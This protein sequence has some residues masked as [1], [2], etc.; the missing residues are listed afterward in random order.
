VPHHDRTHSARLTRVVDIVAGSAIVLKGLS[1]M[2]QPEPFWLLIAA[3]LAGGT[4]ILLGAIFHHRLKQRFHHFAAV[5]SLVE[6]VTS[7]LVGVASVKHG[8]HLI[9]YTWFVAALGFLG[10]AV[11]RVRRKVAVV[12]PPHPVERPL[13]PGRVAD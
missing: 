3:C 13:E 1:K 9:Q 4:L 2:D 5:V 7:A 11:L 8:A 12:D 10:A 6:G